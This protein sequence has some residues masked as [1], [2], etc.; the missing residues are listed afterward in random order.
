MFDS[1]FLSVTR[2]ATLLSLAAS[3]SAP[4]CSPFCDF[5][6]RIYVFPT[7]VHAFQF[8]V[9]TWVQSS[10]RV[11]PPIFRSGSESGANSRAPL[12]PSTF[13]RGTPVLMLLPLVRTGW[14]VDP[15][16]SSL[17]MSLNT[18]V[19]GQNVRLNTLPSPHVHGLGPPRRGGSRGRSRYVRGQ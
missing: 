12:L 5:Y 9:A 19:A 7:P 11:A 2:G 16:G 8:G 13:R 18:P 10:H 17:P 3:V 4:K 1:F 15:T 6:P 14:L